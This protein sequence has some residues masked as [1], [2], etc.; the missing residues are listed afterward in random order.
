VV[1]P[2]QAEARQGEL[3]SRLACLG[4]GHNGTLIAGASRGILSGGAPHRLG[5]LATRL[6]ANT[7]SSEAP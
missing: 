6:A 5:G 7:L 3:I 1:T 4:I 2:N